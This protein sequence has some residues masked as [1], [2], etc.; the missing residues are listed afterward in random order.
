[1][2]SRGIGKN[3]SR[4]KLM[5]PPLRSALRFQESG[6]LLVILALAGFLTWFSGRVA[7]PVFETGPDGTPQRVFTTDAAGDRVPLSI[8]RN[9]FLN[10]QNL[11]QLAKD[12]SFIAIMAVGMSIVIIAGGIDL[13]VGAIYALSSVIGALVLRYYGPNGPA[14]AGPP[15]FGIVLGASAAHYPEPRRPC[16]SR[17]I[18]AII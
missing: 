13:S 6:L 14:S 15:G 5:S 12:T 8:E 1:M 7:M 10:P 3:G 11:A 17:P 16:T 4:N 9:K 18:G 2:N